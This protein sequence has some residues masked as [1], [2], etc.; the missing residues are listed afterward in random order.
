MAGRSVGHWLVFR[1]A[2]RGFKKIDG[3]SLDARSALGCH[4]FD[5]AR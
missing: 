2:E 5:A 1:L 3:S 4:R